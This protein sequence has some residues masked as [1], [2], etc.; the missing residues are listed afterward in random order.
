MRTYT[1]FKSPPIKRFFKVFNFPLNHICAMLSSIDVSYC[2]CCDN[3]ID[4][5]RTM[6]LHILLQILQFET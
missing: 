3:T 6:L 1:H 4:S 5:E 2:E